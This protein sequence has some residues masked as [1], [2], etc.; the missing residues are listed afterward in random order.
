VSPESRSSTRNDPPAGHRNRPALAGAPQTTRALLG[1]PQ[2]C[3]GANSTLGLPEDVH[4]PAAQA[5]VPAGRLAFVPQASETAILGYPGQHIG[6]DLNAH[7]GCRGRVGYSRTA[8]GISEGRSALRR[9]ARCHSKP[10]TPIENQ[11]SRDG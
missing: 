9:G 3:R 11:A 7:T 6:Q 8:F 5:A 2:T 4:R 1:E 10:M